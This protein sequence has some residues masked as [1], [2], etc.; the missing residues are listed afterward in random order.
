[1]T[2]DNVRVHMTRVLKSQRFGLKSDAD[3]GEACVVSAG[4]GGVDPFFRSCPASRR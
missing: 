2:C 3:S 4:L 1:M